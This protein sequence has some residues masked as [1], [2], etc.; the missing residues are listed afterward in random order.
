[1]LQVAPHNHCSQTIVFIIACIE[2][3]R[4]KTKIISGIRLTDIESNHK[5]DNND[6]A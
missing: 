3:K 1:M 5:S 6:N 4:Q 2:Y